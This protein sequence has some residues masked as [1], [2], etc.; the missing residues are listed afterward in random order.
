MSAGRHDRDPAATIDSVTRGDLGRVFGRP[1]K[2][3]PTG[4]VLFAVILSVFNL[5]GRG[6]LGS[7]W[8][9]TVLAGLS[10][11]TIAVSVGGFA[12]RRQRLAEAGLLLGSASWVLRSLLLFWTD[13]VWSPDAWLGLVVAW[14]AAAAYVLESWDESDRHRRR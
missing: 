7:S 6:F 12:A 14:M 9:A 10:L 5:S 11:A 3:F 4:I 13:G 2:P 1:F 8:S